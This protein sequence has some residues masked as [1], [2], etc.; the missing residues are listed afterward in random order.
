VTKSVTF[1]LCAT[2]TGLRVSRCT[3]LPD[4]GEP[5]SV[6]SGTLRPELF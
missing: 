6:L 3:I 5:A 1:E 4:R 2:K